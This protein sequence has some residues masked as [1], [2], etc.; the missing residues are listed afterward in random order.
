M[1]FSSEDPVDPNYFQT[2]ITQP[3]VRTETKYDFNQVSRMTGT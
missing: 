3:Y 1:D 2:G